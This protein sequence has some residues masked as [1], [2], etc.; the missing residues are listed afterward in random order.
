V[1]NTLEQKGEIITVYGTSIELPPVPFVNEIENWGQPPEDQYWRRLP[2]PAI[3]NVLNRDALGNIVLTDEQE[4]YCLLELSRIKDGFWF[5]NNG[6]PT[7]IT[8]RHYYYLKYWTLENK[9]EPEYRDTSRRYFLYLDH[10]R[11]VYWCLGILRGK[12]RRT[13]ATSESTSNGVYEATTV[14]NSNC[15]VLSKTN[16]DARKLFLYRLQFGYRHLPFFLQPT[17]SNAKDS[18]TELV[19]SVPLEGKHKKATLIDAVEGLNSRIDYQ[20]T[21][22]NSYDQER[23]TWLLADEGGKWPP[24]VPFSQ[25]LSIVAET[26]VEGVERVGFGEFPT[27]L[28]EM[29]KKGGAEYKK[30]WDGATWVKQNKGE[31]MEIEDDGTEETANRFVRYFCAAYDGLPGFVGKYGESIIEPPNLHQARWLIAKYGEKK[32]KGQLSLGAKA[33]LEKRRTKLQGAELEEEIRKYPFN[34]VEMFMMD[35]SDCPFNQVKIN[36]QIKYLE[37][38][39]PFLRQ[40]SFYRKEDQT[41]GWRGDKNGLWWILAFPPDKEQNKFKWDG[42]LR[43]PARTNDGTIGVDGYSNSQGGRKYGS[44]ACAM[45]YRKFDINDPENTGCFIGMYYGRPQYKEQMHD[46][47]MFAGE[48]Y[49]YEVFYEHTADDYL[50]HFRSHGRIGY[51]GS[52]PMSAID[53]YKRDKTERFK[54]FPIT[55]FAMTKQLDTMILFIEEYCHKIYFLIFL[56]QALPF[57]PYNRTEYDCIVAGMIALVSALDVTYKP[58]ERTSSFVNTFINERYGK[59]NDKYAVM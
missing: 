20:G 12:G 22:L 7:Y 9:K 4:A 14:K 48:Y 44:M 3:F 59:K 5:Y 8:G 40:V 52:Y 50:G 11:R 32:F 34:E 56:K 51:L 28:N 21:A 33:Y 43:K 26:F 38:K 16:T 2:F 10:W 27:T 49:G 24:E 35:S 58:Q 54:G 13:G 46:Q 30:A 37:D 36:E 41:V 31:D 39:P 25:F 47:M 55:P 23:L 18:K 29:T 45:I 42:R 6:V 57:D 19:W 53:P 17:L 15:G 1:F